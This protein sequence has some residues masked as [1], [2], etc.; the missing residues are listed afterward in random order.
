MLIERVV[1]ENYKSIARCDVKLPQVCFV[2][3]PNGSGKSNFLDALSFVA[4]SLRMGAI[5]ALEKRNGFKHLV[6][7]GSMDTLIKFEIYF[8][9]DTHR[10][11]YKL[12][13]QDPTLHKNAIQYEYFEY[14]PQGQPPFYVENS[15]SFSYERT[16]TKIC[17]QEYKTSDLKDHFDSFTKTETSL[18]SEESIHF[19]QKISI[20]FYHQT[21]QKLTLIQSYSFRPEPIYELERETLQEL[22][23]DGKNIKNVLFHLQKTNGIS[24]KNIQHYMTYLIPGLIHFEVYPI[25][26]Y[27]SL[28]FIMKQDQDSSPQTFKAFQM[29]DGTLLMLGNLTALFQHFEDEEEHMILLEEPKRAL[30][31]AAAGVLREAIMGAGQRNQILITTHNDNLLDHKEVD[32]DSVLVAQMIGG[33]TYLGPVDPATQALIRERRFTVGEPMRTDLLHSQASLDKRRAL[34][35]ARDWT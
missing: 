31:P 13:L 14:F 22:Q 4:E 11:Q 2:V 28:K 15:P 32:P 3:G 21:I 24:Y 23:W 9:T 19:F 18:S 6:P 17:I 10:C 33:Q 1:L 12:Y 26:D 16:E 5:Y 20:P 7:P 35:E 34:L 27:L 25:D 30:H 8:H 29:S